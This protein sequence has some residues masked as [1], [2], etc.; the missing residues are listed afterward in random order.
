MRLGALCYAIFGAFAAAAGFA[1][2]QIGSDT[3][4]KFAVASVKPCKDEFVPDAG[5][6]G[7]GPGPVAVDPGRIRI[8]CMPLENIIM[9]AYVA[10]ADG[11][12]RSLVPMAEQWVRGGPPNLVVGR[13]EQ[14]IDTIEQ[15]E[16]AFAKPASEYLSRKTRS[17]RTVQEWRLAT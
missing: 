1:Q 14:L 17:E 11:Q 7:R 13:P 15:A 6:R 10:Y 16:P 4:P 5:G 8:N 3:P 2:T 9:Q 12:G